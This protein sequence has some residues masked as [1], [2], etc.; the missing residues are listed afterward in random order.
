VSIF[1]EKTVWYFI[2]RLKI[3]LIFPLLDDEKL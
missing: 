2:L 1:Q 3:S